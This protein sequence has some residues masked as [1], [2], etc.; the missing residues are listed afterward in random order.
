MANGDSLYQPN[1]KKGAVVFG[2]TVYDV[3]LLPFEKDLIATI[4]IT[5]AEYRKFV[6]EAK[7]RGAI[8]PAAYDHIPDIRCEPATQTAILVNLAISL[9]L[10][11]AAYLLTPKP[12]MP[13]SSSGGGRIDLGSISGASRFTPSRGFETVTELADYA[14]PIPLLFGLYKDGVGGMLT[15][16]KLVWS[17]MFSHGTMQRAKLLFVVGEQGVAEGDGIEPPALE[18]IFMGNNTLDATSEDFYAFYWK[19]GSV[20]STSRIIG[21]DLTYGT[22]AGLASGAPDVRLEILMLSAPRPKRLGSLM[23]RFVM[24]IHLQTIRSLVCME[25]LRMALAIG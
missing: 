2:P 8:R 3:P 9:V 13:G 17:R 16:P 6:A 21:A 7:R 22:Q 23:R 11:G 14:A 10:T 25:R 19:P 18:G 5:E 12:K 4:G 15:T 20:E 24:P 1:V